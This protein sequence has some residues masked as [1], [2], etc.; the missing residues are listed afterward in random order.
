MARVWCLGQRFNGAARLADFRMEERPIGDLDENQVL[1]EAEFLSVDPYMKALAGQLNAGDVMP[2]S[3]VAKVIKSNSADLAVGRRVLVS[4]GWRN[5][6]VSQL[7]D[8]SLVPLP[9]PLPVSGSHYLGVVGM[10]GLT[11]YSA[12]RSVMRPQPGE[13]VVVSAAAGAVGSLVGQISKIDGAR[14]IGYAGSDDKVKFLKNTLMFDE[15]F[16]YKTSDLATTLKQVAPDGVNCFFDAVG[17]EFSSTVTEHMAM[18]GRVAVIGAISN[19][20]DSTS[21][22]S[23]PFSSLSII[24][25]QLKVQG[26]QYF[27]QDLSSK[28]MTTARNDLATWLS[29]SKLKAEETFYGGFDSMP[30][31]FIDMMSG[32]NTG[33][34]IVRA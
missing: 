21:S 31:A 26:W 12:V 30:K 27:A 20:N 11:A 25:K 5:F 9:E 24:L 8:S 18:H 13:V 6:T 32:K 19:Y 10:T 14:V 16:N 29:Q 2:G 17:G 4:P 28:E 23:G 15:A 22:K 7:G 3:Q 1:L 34:M 33:K